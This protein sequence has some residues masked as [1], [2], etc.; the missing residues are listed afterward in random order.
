MLDH[1]RT[2]QAYESWAMAR[3][4]AALRSVPAPAKDEA[5]L[6]RARGI[7]AHIQMARRMWLSRLGAGPKPAW[8]MFP[9][10]PIDRCER[11]AGETDRAWEAYL[12]TLGEASLGERVPY[13]SL[14]GT[15]FTS[16]RGE[17]LSHV[18]NHSTYHRGQIA[19]LIKQAGGTPATTDL[20]AFTRKG[21]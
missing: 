12:G 20:V 8:E 6:A 2:M 5:A 21:T 10:W 15:P 3:V 9:D 11:E 19:M 1:F 4:I 17:I 13:H 14:D 18:Y 7:F 16:A